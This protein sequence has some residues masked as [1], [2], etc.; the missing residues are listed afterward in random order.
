MSVLEEVLRVTNTKL[1]AKPDAGTWENMVRAAA[2]L[3]D[4]D[5]SRLSKPT[6]EWVNDGVHFIRGDDGYVIVPLE[7][8]KPKRKPKVTEEEAAG[9][10]GLQVAPAKPEPKPKRGRPRKKAG[11]VTKRRT[12]SFKSG[13]V[14]WF[15]RHL[16]E[17][18]G[19]LEGRDVEFLCNEFNAEQPL[20][21]QLSKRTASVLLYDLIAVLR[22]MRDAGQHAH[23]IVE[24]LPQPTAEDEA[25][26]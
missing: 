7:V 18:P 13:K 12:Q 25:S 21:R 24:E 9:E 14:Y 3:S 4:D 5:W 6:K 20:Q 23:V 15:A 19:G 8:P 10:E 17:R 2:A 22:A 1:P 26:Q 16:L 11:D